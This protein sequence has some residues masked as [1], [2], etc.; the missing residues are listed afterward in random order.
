MLFEMNFA[1]TLEF[2][3]LPLTDLWL[4]ASCWCF[5]CFISSTYFPLSY[6]HLVPI[7]IW[8]TSDCQCWITELAAESVSS[9]GNW[10]NEHMIE[11]RWMEMNDDW[12]NDIWK[13]VMK[14]ILLWNEMMKWNGVKWNEVKWYETMNKMRKK[15]RTKTRLVEKK[16][17]SSLAL[18]QNYLEIFWQIPPLRVAYDRCLICDH[19]Q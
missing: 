16:D 11:W 13:L 8:L 10:H 15:K 3:P 14:A 17:S 4:A 12:V 5:R 19:S 1:H 9:C 6:L 18:L 2:W 7:I